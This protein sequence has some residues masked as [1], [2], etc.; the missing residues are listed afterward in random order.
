MPANFWD[1]VKQLVL[2]SF[3]EGKFADGLCAGITLAGKQLKA[4]FP[5]EARDVNE[6]SDDISFGKSDE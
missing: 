3:K 2:S 6:L 5:Y 1:E 4:Y